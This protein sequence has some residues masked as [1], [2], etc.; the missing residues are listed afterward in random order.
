MK[1]H[2]LLNHLENNMQCP[3]CSLSGVSYDDLC[4]HISSAHPE[5]QQRAA[6]SIFSSGC[7][8]VTESEE[9]T[10]LFQAGLYSCDTTRVVSATADPVPRKQRCKPKSGGSSAEATLKIPSLTAGSTRLRCQSVQD[11][12]EDDNR[13]KSE[14]NKAKEKRQTLQR[15]GD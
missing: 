6:R 15:E 10:N 11:C 14:Q 13:V 12:N 1:T 4:F 3:L 9:T 5:K 2:L 8:T 7:C